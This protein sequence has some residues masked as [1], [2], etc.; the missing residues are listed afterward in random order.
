MALHAC[1]PAAARPRQWRHGGSGVGSEGHRVRRANQRRHGRHSG[2]AVAAAWGARAI[3]CIGPA[4]T[5][6]GIPRRRSDDK[7][8]PRS[9]NHSRLFHRPPAVLEG[10]VG[11]V[12]GERS[13]VLDEIK[14]RAADRDTLTWWRRLRGGRRIYLLRDWQ[15]R[16]DHGGD[17]LLM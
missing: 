6:A 13:W 2:G 3:V 8:T 15:T 10:D 12:I 1:H 4:P 14:R 9:R 7:P 11:L 17:P 5:Q 16:R